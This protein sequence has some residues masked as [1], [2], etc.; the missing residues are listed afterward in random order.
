ARFSSSWIRRQARNVVGYLHRTMLN[1]TATQGSRR[2]VG[3]WHGQD[4]RITALA[5]GIRRR[6][7][8]Y[9]LSAI[10]TRVLMS[11]P[12][13]RRMGKLSPGREGYAR[14]TEDRSNQTLSCGRRPPGRS[15]CASSGT[16]GR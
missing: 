14:E 15:G 7:N 5:Y 10:G 9:V 2:T 8:C 4:Q 13:F 3:C 11:C 1:E 6:E 12:P 16:T